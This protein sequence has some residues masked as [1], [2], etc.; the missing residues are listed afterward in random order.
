MDSLPVISQCKSAV[1]AICGDTEGARK[2]QERFLK[3]CPV[4]SQGTSAVQAMMGDTEGARKTQLEFVE[5]LSDTADAVPAVGH[6]KGGIHYACGD[7]EGGDKAMKSSSR[8]VGVLGGGVAGFFVGG[9]PGAFAGGVAG[10]LA[11]DALTTGIDSAVHDE[12][13]PAGTIAAVDVLVEGKS[14]SVSGDVF[15][16]VVGT[17]MDGMSGIA[18]GEQVGR[19][20]KVRIEGEVDAAKKVPQNKQSHVKGAMDDVKTLKGDDIRKMKNQAG[21]L[22]KAKQEIKNNPQLSKRQKSKQ[23][24]ALNKNREMRTQHNI[25]GLTED[26]QGQI[27]AD[28]KP[29]NSSGGRCAERLIFEDS[30]R[31]Y[32]LKPVEYL[33]NHNYGTLAP[34]PEPG[35]LTRAANFVADHAA[36]HG[37]AA[38][39]Y[40]AAAGP[41]GVA[42]FDFLVI[43]ATAGGI[44]CAN[45]VTELGKRVALVGTENMENLS[46]SYC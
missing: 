22:T 18:A 9:P 3:T 19:M 2:T 43:G 6:V 14:E 23:T 20:S 12:F 16:L 10:G 24:K 34:K 15:D 25:H 26:R 8:T 32:Q 37:T 42:K 38:A 35:A 1:Q 27:A 7:K 5:F 33:D 13:R 30:K 46:V 45:R 36:V 17:A 40:P 41:K 31:N 29:Q 44:A 21:D 39:M 11:V 28:L 4:I